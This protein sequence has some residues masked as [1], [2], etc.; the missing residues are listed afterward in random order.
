MARYKLNTTMYL[1]GPNTE[2]LTKKNKNMPQ[3]RIDQSCMK[4]NSNF[5]IFKTGILSDQIR[6]ESKILFLNARFWS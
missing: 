3:K 2:Y 6:F 5:H 1:N 4:I